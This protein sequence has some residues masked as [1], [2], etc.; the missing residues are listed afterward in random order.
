MKYHLKN[1]DSKLIYKT[2]IIAKFICLLYFV[3]F[4][5]QIIIHISEGE[6]LST[7]IIPIILL[8]LSLLGILYRDYFVFNNIELNVVKV[9]G[10]YPFTAKQIINVQDIDK[11]VVT[12]FTKGSYNNDPNFKKKGKA[13][14]AQLSFALRLKDETEE[15]IEIIDEKKSGGFSEAAAFKVSQYLGVEYYQDRSRD[16][17]INVGIR[18]LK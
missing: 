6:P 17:D 18:D 13:Y 7:M 8:L 4:S 3:F 16:L 12:H 11:I 9:F 2:G 14:R 5:W 10:I 1:K 15:I